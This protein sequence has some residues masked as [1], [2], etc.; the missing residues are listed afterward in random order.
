[1]E[2]MEVVIYL[3]SFLFVIWHVFSFFGHEIYLL[4]L[5]VYFQKW[6]TRLNNC[7][8]SR[9]IKELQKI[10]FFTM[11]DSKLNSLLMI[12]IYNEELDE[13]NVKLRTNKLLKRRSPELLL[14]ACINFDHLFALVSL[15]LL[16]SESSRI[17]YQLYVYMSSPFR[18]FVATKTSS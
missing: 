15:L 14:L 9:N 1:M 13:I 2:G 16:L 5:V 3:S 8:C 4:K 11:T 12:L 17:N 18:G 6:F 7:N 10:T